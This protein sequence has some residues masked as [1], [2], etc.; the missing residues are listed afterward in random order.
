MN[1][2]KA[3]ED[4][5]ILKKTEV[6]PKLEANIRSQYFREVISLLLGHE[7]ILE[8]T[9]TVTCPQSWGSILPTANT[10]LLLWFPR[11]LK[12]EAYATKLISQPCNNFG[13][14]VSVLTT[15]KKKSFNTQLSFYEFYEKQRPV[16]TI[17]KIMMSLQKTSRTWELLFHSWWLC[18]CLSYI[19]ATC[20][21]L[22]M[23]KLMVLSRWFSSRCGAQMYRKHKFF[24]T[25]VYR[26]TWGIKKT[27]CYLTVTYS[28]CS[29]NKQRHFRIPVLN[30]LNNLIWLWGS[31]NTIKSALTHIEYNTSI[32]SYRSFQFVSTCLSCRH[33]K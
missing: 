12:N 7:R 5:L 19:T 17:S 30:S 32:S 16:S 21:P 26:T 22:R 25:A 18:I 29:L 13:S 10:P 27:P 6:W 33:K 4:V 28:K 2:A 31:L 24:S 14:H 20:C 15:F 8:N 23:K 11:L 1:A 3:N 9:D